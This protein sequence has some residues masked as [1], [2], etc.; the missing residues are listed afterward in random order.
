MTFCPLL[1]ELSTAEGSKKLR[2]ERSKESGQEELSVH[3]NLA[4]PS[5]IGFFDPAERYRQFILFVLTAIFFALGNTRSLA[6]FLPYRL[7]SHL[8]SHFSLVYVQKDPNKPK[9]NMSAFFLYSK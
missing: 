6:A 8:L 2:V 7:V 1:R 9:R 3:D 4:P 5:P